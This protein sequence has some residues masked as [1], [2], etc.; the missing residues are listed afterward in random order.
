MSCLLQILFV[1]AESC[2][3]VIPLGQ[4]YGSVIQDVTSPNH[5]ADLY[6]KEYESISCR[7]ALTAERIKPFPIRID[8]PSKYSSGFNVMLS[9]VKRDYLMCVHLQLCLNFLRNNPAWTC[10]NNLLITKKLDSDL[11]GLLKLTEKSFSSQRLLLSCLLHSIVYFIS[12]RNKNV[13]GGKSSCLSSNM[14]SKEEFLSLFKK[15]CIYGASTI[16]ELGTSVLFM[17]CG[18]APWWSDALVDIFQYCFCEDSILPLP[19]RR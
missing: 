9:T 2:S 16:T 3:C 13:E 5:N 15:L 19:R 18:K 7:Y 11:S 12:A 6:E 14:L 8:G 10:V 17:L 1:G 4:F